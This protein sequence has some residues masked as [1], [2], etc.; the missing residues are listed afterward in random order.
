MKCLNDAASGISDSLSVR[1][2]SFTGEF[3]VLVHMLACDLRNIYHPG[4]AP[5]L[6]AV[7][8]TTTLADCCASHKRSQSIID[9]A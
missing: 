1:S 5:R 8:S 9:S 4:R 7:R 6:A 2:T 3:P